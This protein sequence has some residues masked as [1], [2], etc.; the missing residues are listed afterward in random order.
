MLK[1]AYQGVPGSFS[2][3]TGVKFFGKKNKFIGTK[4][5]K[6]IFELVKNQKADYG[7]LPI[8]NSIAGSVYENYD[9]L[10]K[11]EVKIVGESYLKIELCLLGVKIKIPLNQ[12]IKLMKK[13]YSHPKALEQCKKFFE[14]HPWLEKVV[15]SDTAGSAKYVSETKDITLGAIASKECAKIYNLQ[16]LKE[17]IE[18]FKNNFTRFLIITDSRKYKTPQTA[19]KASLIFVLPH[20]PGSLYRSLEV[21]AQN[22]L[23]LTKIESRPI[24]TK[25]FEYLFYLD[26]EFDKE[27]F[28]NGKLEKILQ[29][30]KKKT[31]KLK[32]LGFYSKGKI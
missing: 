9:L 12:R 18:D 1:I 15:F 31:K 4:E 32:I 25:P 3:L 11:Y 30:V 17:N 16:V 24:P 8:E 29:E 22:N 13:I 23:N 21:F 27:I 20:V 19:N 5:F 7:I 10:D 26:F 6:E 28:M 2:Y 14:K